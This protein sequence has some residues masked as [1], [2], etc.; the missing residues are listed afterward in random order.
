[1]ELNVIAFLA[2]L[3]AIGATRV[4]ELQISRRHQ[5]E[6][7]RNGVQKRADPQYRWMIILHTAVLLGAAFEVIYLHRPFLP[8]L[9][10]S[11]TLLVALAMALG[12]W[13]IRTLGAHWNVEVMDSAPLGVVTRGPFRWVRHPNYAGVFIELAALPLV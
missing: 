5:R 9:A 13:T 1:M 7:A 4:V 8:V 2:L 11:M 12:W 6:L 10:G 3:G